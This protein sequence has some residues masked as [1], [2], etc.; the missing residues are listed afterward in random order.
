MLLNPKPCL[1]GSKRNKAKEKKIKI[2]SYMSLC[3]HL[4]ILTY[5]MITLFRGFE[6]I[7]KLKII[8]F[9]SK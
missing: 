8:T 3:P 7:N 9:E 5:A 4:Q 1:F 6:N 2:A